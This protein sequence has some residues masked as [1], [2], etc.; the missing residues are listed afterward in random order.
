M[1]IKCSIK[2]AV[3]KVTFA[4]A[5]FIDFELKTISLVMILNIPI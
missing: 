1:D 2:T 3:A 4:T 5:V